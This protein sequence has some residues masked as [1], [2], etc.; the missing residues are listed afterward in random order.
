M[1]LK[2]PHGFS[3]VFHSFHGSMFCGRCWSGGPW[4]G[5]ARGSGDP[6][7][8]M[9]PCQGVLGLVYNKLASPEATLA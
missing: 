8:L 9:G 5:L 3:K 7:G 2:F 1:F 6:V 4:V